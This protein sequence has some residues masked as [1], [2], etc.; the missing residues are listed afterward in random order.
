MSF[1]ILD[2]EY[3]LGIGFQNP[4]YG[5][6]KTEIMIHSGPDVAQDVYKFSVND[7]PKHYIC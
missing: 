2:T 7:N 4:T 5:G 3:K 1:N 6:Y